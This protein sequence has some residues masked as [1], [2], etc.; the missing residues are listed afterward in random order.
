M[1]LGQRNPEI[2]IPRVNSSG[3]ENID[4]IEIPEVD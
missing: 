1:S 4:D 2:S 3:N